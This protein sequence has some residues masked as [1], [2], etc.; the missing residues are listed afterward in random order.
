LRATGNA[1]SLSAGIFD[2]NILKIKI[3]KDVLGKIWTL[4]H[5]RLAAFKLAKKCAPVD[6]ASEQEVKAQMW[7]MTTRNEGTSEVISKG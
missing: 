2:P 7:K 5:R 4:D 6:F 3:W 1:N